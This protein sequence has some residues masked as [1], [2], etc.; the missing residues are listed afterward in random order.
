MKAELGKTVAQRVYIHVSGLTEKDGERWELF[1]SSVRIAGVSPDEQFNV[2][3]FDQD[4][5]HVAFLNNVEFFSDPF[6]GFCEGCQ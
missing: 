1:R 2:V 3:R 5:L 4:G 6:P